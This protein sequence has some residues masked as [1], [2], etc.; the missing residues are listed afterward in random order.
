MANRTQTK[1]QRNAGSCTFDPDVPHRQGIPDPRERWD[2]FNLGA[3][4]RWCV[5]SNS[6]TRRPENGESTR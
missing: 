5:G 4:T 6:F 2:L 3:W 1:P